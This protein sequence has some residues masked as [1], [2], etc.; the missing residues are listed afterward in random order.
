MVKGIGPV[1]APAIRANAQAWLEKRPV[2]YNLL[3]EVCCRDGWM[4]DLE[5]WERA[6][7]TV[8]WCMGWCDAQGSAHI[9]LVAPVPDSRTTDFC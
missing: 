4:F 2:W 5:T 9:A 1:T 8:P 6:G 3:P 7:Q